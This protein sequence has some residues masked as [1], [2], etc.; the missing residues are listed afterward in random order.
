[1]R[2]QMCMPKAITAA[3]AANRAMTSVSGGRLQSAAGA[4]RRIPAFRRKKAA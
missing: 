4:A 3:A 1:M 2:G